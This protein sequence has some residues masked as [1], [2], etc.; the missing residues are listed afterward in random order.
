MADYANIGNVFGAL[1]RLLDLKRRERV[2]A[3]DADGTN[4]AADILNAALENDST[5]QDEMETVLKSVLKGGESG[6]LQGQHS[7]FKTSAEPDLADFFSEEFTLTDS[8]RA[9]GAASFI[10]DANLLANGTVAIQAIEGIFGALRRSMITD[11]QTILENGVATGALVAEGSPTGSVLLTS[12]S[13]KSYALSGTVRLE[14]INETPETILFDLSY[15]LEEELV[16]GTKSIPADNNLQVGRSFEDGPTGLEGVLLDLDTP[17]IVGDTG[18]VFSAL[19]LGGLAAVNSDV[20]IVYAKVTHQTGDVWLVE[21]YS[22]SSRTTLRGSDNSASGL[23]GSTA[24]VIPITGGGSVSVTIDKAAAAVVMPVVG[25]TYSLASFDSLQPRVGDV[26]T[27][28]VTNDEAGN[29][30]T[31]QAK[32]PG[33]RMELPNAVAATA[34]FTD[35]KA[36]DITLP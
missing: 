19:T 3:K 25:N 2:F 24:L 8:D 31:K 5:A 7:T 22:D 35:T 28:I 14:C 30:A 1:L 17:S 12:A 34:G 23:V 33:W 15:D 21:I 26:W 27:F 13:G 36:A 29:F 4:L 18:A 20:G 10:Y 32:V 9:A 16:D 11:S 6:G